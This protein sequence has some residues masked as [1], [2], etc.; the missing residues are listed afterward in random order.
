MTTYPCCRSCSPRSTSS[1]SSTRRRRCC[2]SLGR[3]LFSRPP[4]TSQWAPI[5]DQSATAKDA[6][7]RLLVQLTKQKVKEKAYPDEAT[8]VEDLSLEEG[9]LDNQEDGEEGAKNTPTLEG[10]LSRDGQ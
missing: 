9:L 3:L 6:D 5:L 4:A 7:H 8:G 1:C 10:R 2:L